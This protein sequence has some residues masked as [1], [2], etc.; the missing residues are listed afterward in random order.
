[1]GSLTGSP[2]AAAVTT[3]FVTTQFT[4]I[5]ARTA[6]A[7][8]QANVL[9][10]P[11][12]QGV[13]RTTNGGR[14]WQE[15]IPRDLRVAR[16]DEVI[17]S[18][19]FLNARDAWIT[20]STI[21]SFSAQ[22][23]TATRDGGRRWATVG[24][25]PGR[26]CEVQFLSVSEG[27]CVF[28]SG[29]ASQAQAIVYR[30]VDGGRRWTLMS[31]SSSPTGPP[32]TPGSLPLECDKQI[33]F[34]TAEHGWASFACVVGV[35]PLYRTLDSGRTWLRSRV[36]PL[37]LAAAPAHGNSADWL[38]TPLVRGEHGAAVLFSYTKAGPVTV[39]LTTT[40]GG[41]DWTLA[42]LPG[43]AQARTV[44]LL[45]PSVWKLFRGRTILTST[46]AGRSWHRTHSDLGLGGFTT[47]DFTS[48]TTGWAQARL[49]VTYRTI[50]GGRRWQRVTTPV[51]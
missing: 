50:D 36:A 41:N 25:L 20:H 10:E 17:S 19:D 1:M 27:W 24:R 30:S 28:D 51:P 47:I 32:G 39:I 4:A 33:T 5:G 45:T 6:W 22:T 44:D 13:V 29:A 49:G 2:R 18:A 26:G 3:Q 16:G 12:A 7:R 48:P 31:R 8:T 35:S 21:E 23:L 34:L 40:D 43:G 15:V 9:R 46:N 37:P 38:G 11:F 14:T 42:Q